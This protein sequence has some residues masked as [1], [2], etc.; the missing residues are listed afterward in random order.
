MKKLIGLFLVFLITTSAFAVSVSQ[1]MIEAQGG[2]VR[3]FAFGM[4]PDGTPREIILT[5]AGDKNKVVAVRDATEFNTPRGIIRGWLHFN[6]D[7]TLNRIVFHMTSP[8]EVQTYP[9]TYESVTYD[10]NGVATK[11][12]VQNL[13]A[14]TTN[15]IAILKA[16]IESK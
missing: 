15:K 11:T 6:D 16:L 10:V 1:M 13:S 9:G 12:I 5:T 7:G 3:V 14:G 8:M 2:N 4:L